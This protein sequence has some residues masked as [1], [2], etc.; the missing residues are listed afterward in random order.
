MHLLCLTDGSS[1]VDSNMA[2]TDVHLY[3]QALIRL[4]V[5]AGEK[6]TRFHDVCPR[7]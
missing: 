6:K 3:Q 1:T 2:D 4:L 5:A 7:V